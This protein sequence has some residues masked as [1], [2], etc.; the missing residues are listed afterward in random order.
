MALLHGSDD[1]LVL[2]DWELFA[3]APAAVDL[4][5]HWFFAY[6]AY[7]RADDDQPPKEL[8]KTCAN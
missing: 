2:F 1:A 5:W 7:P 8:L 4:T 6:W 3:R